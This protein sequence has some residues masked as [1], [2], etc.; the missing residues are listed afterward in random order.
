M[1]VGFG[2]LRFTKYDSPDTAMEEIVLRQ[3]LDKKVYYNNIKNVVYS[4]TEQI[5]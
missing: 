2:C 3:F 5:S 4:R 1:I